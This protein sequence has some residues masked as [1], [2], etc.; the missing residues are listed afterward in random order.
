MMRKL[1]LAV[2]IVSL[3]AAALI[4]TAIAKNSHGGGNGRTFSTK[5]TGY[6]EVIPA[7]GAVSTTGR[8]RF[9][10]RLFEDRIEYRLSYENLQGATP[11]PNRVLFAH[12]HFGQLHT[13]GG[14]VAFLCGDTVTTNNIPDACPTPSGSVEGTIRAAD[15]G[16][17]VTPPGQGILA[18]EFGEL[19]RAMRNG[20][21][22]VNV[23]T[24][25]FPAGEIRGQIDGRH[26]GFFRFKGKKKDDD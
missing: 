10:A 18:G 5:L 4:A 20:V 14:V 7:G 25:V 19:I 12:I 17:L 24:T 21:T 9:S 3:G 1:A 22:Y 15:V 13:T 2:A 11:A 26:F 16:T 8:G 6:E 23:H